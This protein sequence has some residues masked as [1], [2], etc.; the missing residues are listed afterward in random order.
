MHI[1]QWE[2]ASN[3]SA[4]DSSS[5]CDYYY[6][7]QRRRSSCCSTAGVR[8]S[9][10]RIPVNL[11]SLA[12]E[13]LLQQL[14]ALCK[15]SNYAAN[16]RA[17][18]HYLKFQLPDDLRQQLLDLALREGRIYTLV[19]VII[20]FFRFLFQWL[21]FLF[22]KKFINKEKFKA[23]KLTIHSQSFQKSFSCLDACRRNIL[24]SIID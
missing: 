11:Q 15:Q 6:L 13:A 22:Q 2:V 8:R 20:L 4:S 7:E 21:H 9:L 5:G 14:V 16:K 10:P 1:D 24:Q 23:R 19:D 3:S 18:K 12:V 17:L